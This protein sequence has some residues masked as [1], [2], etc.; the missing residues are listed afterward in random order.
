MDRA[1]RPGLLQAGSGRE[2]QD[3]RHVR[4][5]KCEATVVIEQRV[6]PARHGSLGFLG[7]RTVECKE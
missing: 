2:R 7:L 4:R 3:L 5:L 6:A 1:R